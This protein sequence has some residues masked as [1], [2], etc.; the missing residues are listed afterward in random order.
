MSNII[1]SGNNIGVSIQLKTNGVNDPVE[2]GA[3]VTASIIDQTLTQIAGPW[4]CSSGTSGANWTT[5]LVVVNVSGT[6]TT[7][8][9]TGG[10]TQPFNNCRFEIKVVE[11]STSL[12]RR[13]TE[14]FQ[15]VKAVL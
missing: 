12:T 3:T 9:F 11:G 6:D 15:L 13:S 4:T 14:T 10:R 1:Y 5:G 2:L 7:A 8:A